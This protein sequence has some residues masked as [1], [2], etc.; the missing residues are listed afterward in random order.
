MV[1]RKITSWALA[2]TVAV[3]AAPDRSWAGNARENYR[4]YCV[5]C[6]GTEANGG[7]INNTVGG[8]AVSP[9]DH[10]NATEMSKLSNQDIKLVIDK[11]G[12]VV[13]K[14]ELMPPWGEVLK[15]KEIDELVFYLRQLCRCERRK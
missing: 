8:L 2:V 5:Q 13:S 10:T 9:R 4:L 12:D 14:S 7:G 1:R 6:H 3:I 15:E 11:G